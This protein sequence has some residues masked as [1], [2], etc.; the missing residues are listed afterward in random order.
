MLRKVVVEVGSLDDRQRIAHARGRETIDDV[1]DVD[2]VETGLVKAGVAH[3]RGGAVLRKAA[4]H[5][6][7]PGPGLRRSV[8]KGD[9]V[10][11]RSADPPAHATGSEVFEEL[12][13]IAHSSS[14]VTLWPLLSMSR[15]LACCPIDVA[16]Q[17][18]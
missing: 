14:T 7:P 4:L 10:T 13:L 3:H 8:G 6:T 5:A 2:L 9:E 15:I 1:F 18:R 16:P 17:V 11:D 12:L